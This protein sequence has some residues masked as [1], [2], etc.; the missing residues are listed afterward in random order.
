MALNLSMMGL[1]FHFFVKDEATLGL[2]KIDNAMKNVTADAEEMYYA[3]KASLDAI[4]PK[5]GALGDARVQAALRGTGMALMGVGAA[6]LAASGLAVKSFGDFEQEMLNARSVAGWTAEEFQDLSRYAIKVGADTKFSARQVAGAMYEIASAGVSAAEDV[7]ALLRPIADFAAAGAIDLPEATRAI[8][9]AVQGFRLEMSDAAHVA[10]VFTAAVQN[11]ML[12]ASEFDVALGS[13]AGVAGQVGQSLEA[14]MAGL[15]A[16]R[17]VIGSA[18]DAATSMKSA[19]MSLIAPTSEA[20]NI[21]DILGIKLRDAQGNMKPWPEIIREFELSFAAAGKLINQFSQFAGASDDE[22]KALAQTYGL[23]KE[24]ASGLAGAA[25]QGTKAFQDYVLASIFG[26]DGIRAVAA[27]LNAQA[28]TMI[29]GREVTLRGADALAYWQQ[30]LESSAGTAQQAA[31]IQM[32]GLNGAFEQLR[33]SVEAVGLTIG[34]NLAPTVKTIAGLVER[35]VDVFNRMPEG[36][37]RAAT[38]ALVGGSALAGLAGAGFLFVSMIPSFV[39]GLTIMR[40]TLI[41][42]RL[43]TLGARAATLAHAGIMA[44]VRGATLAWAGAQWVLNAALSANPIGIIIIAATALA[45]IAFLVWR[46]WDRVRAFF[47]GLW[48]RVVAGFNTVRT[49]IA[50]LPGR[51]AAFASQAGEFL[52][53]LFLRDIPYWIGYGL[54]FMIRTAGDAIEATVDFFRALPGRVISWVSNLAAQLPLWWNNITTTAAQMIGQG[55]DTV[56]DFFASLPARAGTCLTNLVGT[57]SST[58]ASLWQAAYRAGSD[59]VSGMIDA[60][61][62]LPGRVGEIL[63]SVINTITGRIND[64]WSAARTAAGNLWAGFKAGLGIH[65]P[66]YIERALANITEASQATVARLSVDFRRLSGLTAEPQVAM[67]VSY[68]ASA[69]AVPVATPTAT[70]STTVPVIVTRTRQERGETASAATPQVITRQPIKLVLDG[71]T[72]AETVIEF[73]EDAQVRRVV[74]A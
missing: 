54:G 28:K 44:V 1:G 19:L 67:G 5:L 13:V 42:A 47:Q 34:N 37:Q 8:V 9:A 56:V 53:R 25:A 52:E 74:P 22:L 30:K 45:G 20:S 4:E 40:T 33:G 46:N 12:K 65:S 38:W 3:T 14:T 72:I 26:S 21:M 71:R 63:R 43:A 49:T 35:A 10:D 64:F 48:P 29:N 36:M 7:K 15:M 62:G 50:E 32:S 23:T 39:Q 69:P 31:E 68:S 73:I 66:S 55:I 16:A 59:M 51:I 27:G 17:N 61:I 11:S 6:G 2:Q 18:Q 24:Q 41:G 58:A 57:V 60:I 70:T